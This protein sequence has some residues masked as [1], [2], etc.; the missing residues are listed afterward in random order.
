[1]KRLAKTRRIYFQA[2][3]IAAAVLSGCSNE[4][5]DES[6]SIPDG[7]SV[8]A[9]VGD[10]AI[11]RAE[12]IAAN[13]GNSGST[14]ESRR[15]T[16]DATIDT[17]MAAREARRR[18]L[19]EAPDVATKILTIRIEA[20][21]R[22]RELLRD[23]LYD[24]VRSELPVT[25]SELQNHYQTTQRRY[26]KRQIVVGRTEY[27][28]HLEASNALKAKPASPSTERLGPLPLAKL[29]A[30]VLPEAA[31]LRKIGDRGLAEADDGTWSVI[32][33]I[34]I[35]AAEPLAFAEVREAVEKNYRVRKGNE[36]FRAL[37]DHLRDDVEIVINEQALQHNDN[38]S[39]AQRPATN[40]SDK[41][42]GLK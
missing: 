10:V 2:L 9:R 32:E 11:T 8:V 39:S 12:L 17:R 28:S 15:Q 36:A 33:L 37:L 1:M 26:A 23:A 40:R 38:W 29:P 27:S 5:A 25:E 4:V 30:S 24:S 19:H 20:Q 21:K 13:S 7:A 34:E 6:R 16:L 31:R 3:L 14:A 18:G 41:A 22:E 42:V 35:L